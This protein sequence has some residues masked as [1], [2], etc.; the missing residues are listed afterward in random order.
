M[1]EVKTC[2]FISYDGMT[3]PLGQSQVL[4]YLKKIAKKYDVTLLSCEKK[5]NYA[6]HT[7]SISTICREANIDW[8]PLFYTKKPPILSTYWDILKITKKV[9]KLHHKKQFQLIHCRSLIPALIGNK[10]KLKHQTKFLFDMRGFWADERVDG[11]L[12]NLKNPIYKRV[13][14][15]FK[16]KER[17]FLAHADAVISLT[18]CGKDEI[19]TWGINQLKES[20]ITVIPCCVDLELFNP[21]HIT[22]SAIQTLKK[23]LSIQSDDMILGYVG[24]IGTWYMLSEMLDYFKVAQQK[25]NQLKFLFVTSESPQFIYHQA[26]LKGINLDLILVTKC[27]YPEVAKHIA[28][29]DEAIFFIKPTFS[30][31][32]SSPTKQGE[33]MAMGIP[34][35]CND[36]I[37][38]TG[39]LIRKYEAGKVI[40]EF[41]QVSYENAIQQ[42]G[43]FNYQKSIEGAAS[44]FSLETGSNR[45]LT[46]YQSLIGD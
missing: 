3:D 40:S 33:I 44:Y 11:G 23:Q 31:K 8:H 18:D 43:N 7:S 28:L 17:T 30:K 10:F 21:N 41:N 26:K 45:Y 39:T 32:A 34:I 35:I 16:K 19:L 29:F 36:G 15:Y 22:T 5:E 24:S 46:I 6:S 13:Y 25:N 14:T 20:K 38:D 12:W 27:S 9:K 4:P 1:D 2:L 37:G 42:V